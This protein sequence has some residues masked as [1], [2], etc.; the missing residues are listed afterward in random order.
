ML[1]NYRQQVIEAVLKAVIKGKSNC[2]ASKTFGIAYSTLQEHVTA[3][4][5]IFQLSG[6]FQ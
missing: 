3:L 1:C 6:S 2:S 5:A 4:Q